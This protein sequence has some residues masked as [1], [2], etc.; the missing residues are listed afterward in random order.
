MA[1]EIEKKYR[2]TELEI[3]RLNDRLRE[4]AAVDQ[5]DEFEENILFFG[6]ALDPAR[7]VLRLRKL[8]GR[9]LLTYKERFPSD[10][11]IKHQREDESLVDDPDALV[12]IL[13]ALGFRP[14]LVYEKRRRTW[15]VSGAEVVLDELP[16]GWYA[17]IEGDEASIIA[18]ETALDLQDAEVEH[19]TYPELTKQHGRQVGDLVEA[20][21]TV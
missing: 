7:T 4:L 1:I 15:H 20:R 14:A 13:G 6:G 11:A 10:S 21:F 2:L 17:E 5:G 8:K 12:E 3:G 16:F 9:A 19:L 18:A